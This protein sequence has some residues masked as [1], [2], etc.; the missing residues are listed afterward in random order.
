MEE[1]LMAERGNKM[2][3]ETIAEWRKRNT[4]N[5]PIVISDEQSEPMGVIFIAGVVTDEF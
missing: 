4:T 3:E 1:K 5:F 2:E